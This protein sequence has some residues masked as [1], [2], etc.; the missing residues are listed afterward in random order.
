MNKFMSMIC[1]FFIFASGYYFDLIINF[2]LK[3]IKMYCFIKETS[4]KKFINKSIK[5]A[6]KH[7]PNGNKSSNRLLKIFSS[8]STN[9]DM[10]MFFKV[11]F[12]N[13]NSLAKSF[14]IFLILIFFANVL[15]TERI[16]LKPQS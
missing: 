12:T 16:F 5:K 13:F 2:L 15:N 6:S 4:M 7:L 11:F 9:F 8:V 3:L 14:E 10:F 1:L